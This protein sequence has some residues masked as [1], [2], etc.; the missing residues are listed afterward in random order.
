MSII[1]I[2]RKHN[3]QTDNHYFPAQHRNYIFQKGA[4]FVE[5]K[6]YVTTLPSKIKSVANLYLFK[7]SVKE[8][9]L[10]VNFYCVHDLI[11]I[12]TVIHA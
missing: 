6:L 12:I 7:E 1:R 9:L 2:S 3:A 8:Y 5:F 10:N 11:T 4:C